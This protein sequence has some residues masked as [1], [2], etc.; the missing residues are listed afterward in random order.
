[1][2]AVIQLSLFRP[3]WSL[4]LQLHKFMALELKIFIL[5]GISIASNN[6]RI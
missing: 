1:M 5:R 4:L 6:G 2:S 3:A